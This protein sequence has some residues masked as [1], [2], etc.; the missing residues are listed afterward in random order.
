MRKTTT[1]CVI[2]AVIPSVLWASAAAA[3][4]LNTELSPGV[5]TRASA[6]DDAAFGTRIA[7]SL[8]NGQLLVVWPDNSAA[9]AG[10]PDVPNLD[11]AALLTGA[12]A[13]GALAGTPVNASA[14][15]GSQTAPSLAR[16]PLD[17]N[18]LVLVSDGGAASGTS[19]IAALPGVFRAISRDGGLTW[20]TG[21]VLP[22]HHSAEIGFDAQGN[23]FALAIDA[24]SF[25]TPRAALYVSTDGG[26]QFVAV[27]GF[28]PPGRIS[29]RPNLAVGDASVWMLVHDFDTNS[30]VAARAA[31]LGSGQVGA[32]SQQT[33]S[34]SVGASNADL[35]VGPQGNALA[36]Y[37]IRS[38]TGVGTIR[39]HADPD[40]LGAAPF[41][42]GVAITNFTSYNEIAL[43]RV[44]FDHGTGPTRGRAYDI[45]QEEPRL[46]L[47]K[48]M[49]LRFSTDGGASWSAAIRLNDNSDLSQRI[50]P[51]V[52]VDASSGLV[53]AAWYDFRGGSTTQARL[54][55][56][57]LA[58]PG[59]PAEP[60]SPLNLSARG[61]STSEIE[62]TW[63]DRS[64]NET[65]F[66]I[67][68]Q[69][70]NL[71][72]GFLVHATVG[73]GVS[74]FVDGGHTVQSGFTYRVRAVN[75]AGTS[76][77]TNEA[78]AA[79]LAVA[80]A[81][82]GALVARDASTAQ[83]AVDLNWVDNS[84]NEQGFELQR[85]LDGN[86][87][88]PL[89][90]LG[91]ETVSATDPGVERGKRYF[92]RVRSVNSG[93]ASG[94]SNVASVLL[95]A[96]SALVARSVSSQRIDL[97]W[98]DNSTR[99]QN[100][101]V[102]R[103]RDGRTWGE[104]ATVAAN[105]TAYADRNLRRNTLYYYRVRAKHAEGLTGYTNYSFATTA[106]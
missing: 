90:T 105:T 22:G 23:L 12:T 13:S 100:F 83:A 95:D 82:P 42:A 78:S 104:I 80:P 40:G 16:N 61:I 67:E 26:Q 11:L 41:N 74:T 28:V 21:T 34:G 4:P 81:A 106:R 25:F 97:T 39:A 54:F 30:L 89:A 48:E 33:L 66:V 7:A 88:A 70:P 18:H 59:K 43:P 71:F 102:E 75:A 64:D 92:Y 98:V 86:S 51:A 32:F 49:H 46:A 58:A 77:Y 14:L 63:T 19:G 72:A 37:E 53:A 15:A 73:A 79:T 103:S 38:A 65:G 9:L 35:A 47:N 20:T 57:A 87:F 10:N 84:S 27:A 85:S 101:R 5:I 94:F 60:N 29:L 45:H 76:P 36:V 69:G 17:P 8:K 99:E 62:L 6:F 96:P 91:A 93:G 31:S 56:T 50:V 52:A 1:G 44:A 24:R 68:R 2:S 55:G 3:P